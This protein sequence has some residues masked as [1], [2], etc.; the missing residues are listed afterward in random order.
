M[1]RLIIVNG[2]FLGCSLPVCAAG[3]AVIDAARK[4]GL[5]NRYMIQIIDLLVQPCCCGV[6]KEIKRSSAPPMSRVYVHER[7]LPPDRLRSSSLSG[8]DL[9]LLKEPLI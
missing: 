5:V 8:T 6:R 9:N 3:Q 1:M 4:D 7:A 2:L